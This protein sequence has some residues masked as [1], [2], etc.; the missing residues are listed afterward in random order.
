MC[1]QHWRKEKKE[2]SPLE[3]EAGAGSQDMKEK[4]I[5]LMKV[6]QPFFSTQTKGRGTA[7]TKVV[8]EMPHLC[9]TDDV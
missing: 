9:P 1:K 2:N 3:M 7:I 4:T 8:I 6:S 5:M